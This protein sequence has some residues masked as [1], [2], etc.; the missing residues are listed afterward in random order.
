MLKTP[1]ASD[2]KKADA[3]SPLLAALKCAYYIMQQRIISNPKDLMGILLYG[4]EATKFC[5]E[6]EDFRGGYSFPHC[7][8]L[9]DLNVP[10]AED[11]KAL[12]RLVENDSGTDRDVF[13]R[14]KKPV[15]MHTVL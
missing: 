15:S 1:P 14:S 7:Y 12:K 8:L 6:S 2:S 4:T 10:E 3:N 5:G 11:V 13:I 9:T